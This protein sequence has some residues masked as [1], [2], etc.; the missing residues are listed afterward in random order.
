MMKNAES[1]SEQKRF[2]SS[3][4]DTVKVKVRVRHGSLFELRKQHPRR[5][6]WKARHYS[7]RG[8]FRGCYAIVASAESGEVLHI[9]ASIPGSSR[10]R[11]WWKRKT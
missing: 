2:Y 6:L 7:V 4:F 10:V 9:E 11:T 1:T 3:L 5:I 8:R